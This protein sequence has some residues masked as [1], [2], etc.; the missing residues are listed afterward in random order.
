M[1][2]QGDKLIIDVENLGRVD[3]TRRDTWHGVALLINGSRNLLGSPVATGSGAGKRPE[4]A[5]NRAVANA[6]EQRR[7][8]RC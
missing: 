7:K 8:A 1:K 4:V 6:F 5:V 3:G 2:V